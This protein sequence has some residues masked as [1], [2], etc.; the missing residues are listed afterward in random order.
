MKE[1][2]K[3]NKA[4]MVV[5]GITAIFIGGVIGSTIGINCYV[6]RNVKD[7]NYGFNDLEEA[8]SKFEELSA[9]APDGTIA[10]WN[11]G[12]EGFEYLVQDLR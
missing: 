6:K 12:M 8:L 1:F 2:L 10:L 7:F 5:V 4:K 11:G 9:N 3:K